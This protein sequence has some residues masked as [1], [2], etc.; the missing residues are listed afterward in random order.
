MSSNSG[1]SSEP[2][3]KRAKVSHKSNNE[4]VDDV[5]ISDE[6]PTMTGS[7]AAD[8]AALAACEEKAR[9]LDEA[10]EL[11]TAL[12]RRVKVEG[13]REELAAVIE[14]AKAAD[15]RAEERRA[16]KVAVKVEEG[17]EGEEYVEGGEEEEEEEEEEEGEMETVKAGT[18]WHMCG[19]VGCVYKSKH[20][21]T[22]K[23]HKAAIHGIDVKWVKCD[24]CEYKCKRGST[25]KTH[26]AFVHDISVKWFKCDQCE[27]KSKKNSNLKI[28][29]AAVHG[30]D[31]KWIKCDKCAYKCK[32]NG[33]L[34]RH[35]ADV[36]DVDVKWSKCDQCDYK[37][38]QNGH[39]KRHKARHYG[40]P[41]P[42]APPALSLGSRVSI[43]WPAER[44]HFPGVVVGLLGG[45]VKIEYDDGDKGTYDMAKEVWRLEK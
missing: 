45:E 35:K 24:Q 18:S 43:F 38:K 31:V 30:I 44:S 27:H 25:L 39:L 13:E 33:G 37:C 42:P 1:T 40:S 36:H 26:K 10:S 16:G 32:Q 7:A 4:V 29:K 6:A 8:E 23:Q 2:P 9:E 41:A 17:A 11:R 15:G 19:I 21:G 12:G 20:S 14:G 3:A 28:H 5:S 22:L 34:K